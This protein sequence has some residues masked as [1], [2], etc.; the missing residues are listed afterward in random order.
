MLAGFGSYIEALYQHVAETGRSMHA[1]ALV[2]F[3]GDGMSS[4]GRSLIEDRFGVPVR[5]VYASMEAPNIGFEC[6][7]GGG[8]HLNVDMFPVR[9]VDSGG[10]EC[11][12]GV[13]GDVVVSNLISRGTVL[14]NYRLGDRAALLDRDCECGRGLPLL[15]AIEGRTYDWLERLDGERLHPEALKAMFR[16]EPEVRGFQIRQRERDRIE[17]A[18]VPSADLG[19]LEE[20]LRGRF[21]EQ[22]G[23]PVRVDVVTVDDLP[24]T[25]NGKVKTVVRDI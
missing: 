19:D 24:R 21:S 7:R 2:R 12:A 14:I 6:E 13:V 5:S 11:P 8:F 9:I 23:G 16:S 15:S 10:D 17:V 20:R 25:S 3:G 1:P 4:R 22:L 18:V